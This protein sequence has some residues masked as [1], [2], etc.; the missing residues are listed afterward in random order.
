VSTLS[1]ACDLCVLVRHL[2]GSWVQRR[3]VEIAVGHRLTACYEFAP[4]SAPSLGRRSSWE[5]DSASC[6]VA[7]RA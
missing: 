4:L 7:F 1:G 3:L 6:L 5:L 2:M